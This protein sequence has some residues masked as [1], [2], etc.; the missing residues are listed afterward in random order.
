MLD[1]GY[2]S[3]EN[4][5]QVIK[6]ARGQKYRTKR[7]ADEDK[8]ASMTMNECEGSSHTPLYGISRGFAETSWSTCQNIC[9]VREEYVLCTRKIGKRLWVAFP[10]VGVIIE[11]RSKCSWGTVDNYSNIQKQT[12]L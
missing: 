10:W 12:F 7:D 8:R 2:G 5:S 3:P 1:E 6:G 11:E 9:R 4:F